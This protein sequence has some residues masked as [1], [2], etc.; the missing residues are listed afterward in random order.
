[1]LKK[2]RTSDF[3]INFLNCLLPVIYDRS[4]SDLGSEGS[5]GG[6][7]VCGGVGTTSTCRYVG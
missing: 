1:M 5:G 6:R 2:F 4:L 3:P 7:E